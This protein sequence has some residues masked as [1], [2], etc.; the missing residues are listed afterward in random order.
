MPG[1][2]LQMRAVG[3]QVAGCPG[4]LERRG[5]SRA[6]DEEGKTRKAKEGGQQETPGC[7]W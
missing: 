1:R 7:A 4:A 2:I 5:R 3:V 6:Q